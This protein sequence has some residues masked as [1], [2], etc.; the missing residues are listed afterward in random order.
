MGVKTM[1][2]P[3]SILHI[4]IYIYKLFIYNYTYTNLHVNKYWVDGFMMGTLFQSDWTPFH[5]HG[6]FA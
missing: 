2:K 6:H 5:S 3:G 4:Y 1:T